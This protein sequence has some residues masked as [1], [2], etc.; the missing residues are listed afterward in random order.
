M[1]CP[2]IH[3]MCQ[4]RKYG[5]WGK[6]YLP[7]SAPAG[8]EDILVLD[9]GTGIRN[10]GNKL[11]EEKAGEISG[12]IFIT[13]PHWDHIQGFPFFKPIYG[14]ANHFDIHMPEQENGGCKEI[15][16]GHLTK[17]F[18]PVTLKMIDA[19][20]SY[21]TQPEKK[22]QYD[23]YEVEFMLANHTI[24]TAIYKIQI[25]GKTIIFCPDNEM[26]PNGIK[27]NDTFY[28]K[29]KTFCSGAD[30][31][32]HDAQYDLESYKDRRGWGHSAWEV[33]VD[34]ARRA[35]VKHLFLTHHDPDSSDEK[36]RNLDKHIQEKF[37]DEFESIQIAKEGEKVYF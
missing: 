6:H 14:S 24:K 3:S 8:T 31:L 13:H 29:L 36:L 28:E 10:L 12:R 21:I 5:V 18:F 33:V 20:L 32:V 7:T 17:T 9:S 15:L 16:S 4:S 34:F 26:D 2:G 1:G 22:V 23:G 27:G 25:N 11:N 30:L 37:G 35:E 19:N